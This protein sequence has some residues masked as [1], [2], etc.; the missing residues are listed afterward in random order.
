MI[1]ETGHYALILALGVAIVQAMLPLV[2][3]RVRDAQLAAV[4]LPAA[5]LQFVLVGIAFVALTHRLRHLR[6]LG[7]ECLA[8]LA[9]GQADALQDLGRVGE[10]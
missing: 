8:E 5:Q 6:L 10:P 1:A 2:G 3:M 4:A 9:F 7:P